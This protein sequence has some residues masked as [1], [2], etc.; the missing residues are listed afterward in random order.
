MC[1]LTFILDNSHLLVELGWFI[2]L[3]LIFQRLCY[4]ITACVYVW[5][6]VCMVYVWCV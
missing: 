1:N 5:S 4:V 6:G 3:F 2:E